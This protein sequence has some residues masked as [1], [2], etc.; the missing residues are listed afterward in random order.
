MTLRASP[1]R[2]SSKMPAH[3][4]EQ[5]FSSDLRVHPLLARL[6]QSLYLRTPCH[7]WPK[8]FYCQPPFDH[9]CVYICVYMIEP[10]KRGRA[11]IPQGAGALL[12]SRD[13]Y[14]I[15]VNIK[16]GWCQ[17]LV[18]NEAMQDCASCVSRGLDGCLQSHYFSLS[19]ILLDQPLK[20]PHQQPLTAP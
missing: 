11:A 16:V 6:L 9:G 1:L 14:C 13:C 4:V 20:Q 10:L 2:G 7:H 12:R 17:N 18:A 5:G 8:P 19:N 3:L 15:W